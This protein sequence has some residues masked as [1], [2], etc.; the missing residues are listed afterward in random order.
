[1]YKNIILPLFLLVLS[2]FHGCAHTS[3]SLS[4]EELSEEFK[5]VCLSGNGKGRITYMDEKFNFRFESLLQEEMGTWELALF[6]AFH[7]EEYFKLHWKEP[8]TAEGQVIPQADPKMIKRFLNNLAAIIKFLTN[9]TSQCRY[10]EN[11]AECIIGEEKLLFNWDISSNLKLTLITSE[12][13]KM[14]LTAKSKRIN[15]YRQ[16]NYEFIQ[17]DKR[18]IFLELWPT[19]L[20]CN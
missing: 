20:A 17:N 14:I 6:F 13:E 11:S 8:V 1:M 18:L 3:K 2:Q 10:S 12:Q 9:N 16:L 19:G 15:F 5:A 7:G 4:S